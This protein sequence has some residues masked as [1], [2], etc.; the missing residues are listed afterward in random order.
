MTRTK[1]GSG[2]LAA[3]LVAAAAVFLPGAGAA[4]DRIAVAG[5]YT[6]SV[7][8]K[9]DARLHQQTIRGLLGTESRLTRAHHKSDVRPRAMVGR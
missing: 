3:A 2:V 6:Q 4:A 7:R 5:V 8:Q 1:P 9:W